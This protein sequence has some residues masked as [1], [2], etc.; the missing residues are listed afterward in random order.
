MFF[1]HTN[2]FSRFPSSSQIRHLCA[3]DHYIMVISILLLCPKPVGWASQVERAEPSESTSDPER[4]EPS[5]QAEPSRAEPE[6]SKRAAMT[7]RTT[8]DC[9]DRHHDN[10]N[11]NNNNLLDSD[12]K[13][14][15]TNDNSKQPERILAYSM[16]YIDATTT[17]WR[18]NSNEL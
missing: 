2:T 16:G 13:T 9:D 6:P 3:E 15:N 14:N 5:K 1:L 12:S 11:N 8:A 18:Y 17:R 7:T 10:N 4:A